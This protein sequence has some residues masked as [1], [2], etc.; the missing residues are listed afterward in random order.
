M[1]YMETNNTKIKSG[2]SE[3]NTKIFFIL[4]FGYLLE[5]WLQRH[6]EAKQFKKNWLVVNS[7]MFKGIKNMFR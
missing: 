7:E 3:K 2:W 4:D 5:K 1:D 6:L